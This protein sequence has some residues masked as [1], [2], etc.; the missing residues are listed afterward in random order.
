MVCDGA[1]AKPPFL[2]WFAHGPLL[3]TGEAE[4]S[5][6]TSAAKCVKKTPDIFVKEALNAKPQFLQWFLMPR[7][8]NISFY[9]ENDASRRLP[10]L[11]KTPPKPAMSP[12]INFYNGL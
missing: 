6:R 8:V 10:D 11:L 2:R 1:A 5:L 7:S 3:Q 12:T 4:K 9:N